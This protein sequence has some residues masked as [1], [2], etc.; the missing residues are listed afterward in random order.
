M[1][2]GYTAKDSEDCVVEGNTIVRG[3]LSIRGFTTVSERD[4]HVWR[5]QK[6]D[7]IPETAAVVL[8]PSKYDPNRAN[9][10]IVNWPKSETV[11]VDASTLLKAGDAFRIQSALDFFGKPVVEGTYEG[12]PV[13][14]PMPVEERTGQGEFCA[15]VVFRRPSAGK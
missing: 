15:F 4:N 13:T 11:D 14:V 8:R 2:V 12:G 3:G 9:L 1:S 10:A 5:E 6:K 7:P